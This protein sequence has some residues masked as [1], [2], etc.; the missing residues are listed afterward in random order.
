MTPDATPRAPWWKGTRG[1]WWVVGQGV[2][3]A[4]VVFAPP[5]WR[6]T[7]PARALWVVLGVGLVASGLALVARAMR[8]L[9]PHLSPF[10]RPRRDAVLVTTGAFAHARHP[11][12]GGMI[13][14][15]IGWALWRG[16]GLHLLLAAVL[17]VYM[18]AKASHEEA[19]LLVRFDG[20]GAYRQGR[21]RLIPWL[22]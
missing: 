13:V 17:A 7:A 22:F 21:K 1:E 8:D 15:A 3:M 9:G 19:L 12:Y 6:W 2:L 4:A 10:P 5:A 16:S 11:I 14:A 20:Y 18:N